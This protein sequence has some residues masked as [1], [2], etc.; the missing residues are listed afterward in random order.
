MF[1]LH[2]EDDLETLDLSLVSPDDPQTAWNFGTGSLVHVPPED[3][4]AFA[5]P[6][7]VFFAPEMKVTQRAAQR[8][9]LRIAANPEPKILPMRRRREFSTEFHSGYTAYARR[10]ALFWREHG[11]APQPIFTAGVFALASIQTPIAQCLKLC[12][13]LGPYL[14]EE[15]LPQ[16]EELRAIVKASGTGLESRRVQSMTEMFDYRL[17]VSEAINRDRLMDND[18]RKSL[19]LGTRLPT[20]LGMA[21]LSFTLAL[22]GHNLGCLDARILNWAFGGVEEAEE[23]ISRAS[24]KSGG[25]VTPTAYATYRDAEIKILTRTP[26][27]DKDD[28]VGLA[29]SQW[30]LWEALGGE[31][32]RTHT[33]REMFEAIVDDR[34]DDLVDEPMEAVQSIA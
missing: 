10:H 26:Y 17:V 33:H 2:T 25:S 19:A 13:M 4:V 32:M 20:G 27:F 21:K 23:F 6:G 14:K 31:E 12:A 7:S 8:R 5:G 3:V 22:M 24:R 28:P 9:G 16:P 11:A 15:R 29:R 30:M 18:L 1:L 34:L